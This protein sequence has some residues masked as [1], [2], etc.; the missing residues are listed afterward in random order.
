MGD[1]WRCDAT[2]HTCMRGTTQH[3]Q[4]ECKEPNARRLQPAPACR[5]PPLPRLA[6]RPHLRR[7]VH[8]QQREVGDV[9]QRD[10]DVLAD[11]ERR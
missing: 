2:Q 6:Q 9:L 5:H 3:S 7:P 4:P 10:V 8:G 1:C 11:L